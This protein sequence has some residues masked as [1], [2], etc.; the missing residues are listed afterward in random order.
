MKKGEYVDHKDGNRMNN[1][2][3]NLRIVTPQMNARNRK[4][5][6]DNYGVHYQKQCKKWCVQINDNDGKKVTSFKDAAGE[7]VPLCYDNVEEARECRKY[8]EEYFGGGY[9]DRRS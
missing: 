4:R 2:I 1:T 8:L 9:T 5:N 7:T 3:K 6:G